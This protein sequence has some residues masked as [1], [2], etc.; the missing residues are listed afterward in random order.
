MVPGISC[1]GPF[2]TIILDQLQKQFY[3]SVPRTKKNSREILKKIF[4]IMEKK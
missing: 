4:L 2:L 1:Y 3:I